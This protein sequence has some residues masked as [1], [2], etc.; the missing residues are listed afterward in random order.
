MKP[1][2]LGRMI[3]NRRKQLGYTL[4]ELA[5]R[6]ELSAP[7]LSQV[8]KGSTTPSVAS[9]VKIARALGVPVSYFLDTE[10]SAAQVRKGSEVRFFNLN[11]S[12]VRYGRI[13]STAPERQ[14][15]PLLMIYPPRY[16]SAPVTHGGEEFFY[17][18]CGR[19]R[20]QIGEQTYH[21][22]PGDSAHFNSGLRH[23]WSNE[24]DE[25]LRVLWVGTPPLL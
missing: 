19:M 14:L 12:R 7:F 10:G 21:L 16:T 18:L 20:L 22:G 8:E 25:E 9:M 17:I 13:G 15:E 1:E 24:G 3:Q 4:R 2:E 11:E 5:E 6:A 23:I